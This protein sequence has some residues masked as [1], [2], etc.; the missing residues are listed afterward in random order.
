MAAT[1]LCEGD[2]Y[3]LAN[4]YYLCCFVLGRSTTICR[5]DNVAAGSEDNG[6]WFE[7]FAAVRGPSAVLDR[8]QGVRP[9]ALSLTL[10]RGNVAHSSKT[11]GITYYSPGWRPTD[12]EQVIEDTKSYR[13]LISGMLVHANVNIAIVGGVLADNMKGIWYFQN[14]NIRLENLDVIGYSSEYKAVLGAT[15]SEY[16][17]VSAPSSGQLAGIQIHPWRLGVKGPS[18]LVPQGLEAIDIR[19]SGFGNGCDGAAFEMNTQHVW[20]KTYDS[21]D[22]FRGISFGDAS[23]MADVC[24]AMALGVN[25]IAMHDQDGSFGSGSEGFVVSEEVSVTTFAGSCSSIGG[26]L[27]FCEGACLRQIDIRTN[28]AY[29]TENIEMV[30][31]DGSTE[32]TASWSHY[33]HQEFF[34]EVNVGQNTLTTHD[35]WYGLA[36]PEGNFQISFR[37]IETGEAAWPDYAEIV[38]A[39]APE[40]SGYATNVE[41]TMPE[42]DS[43]RCSSFIKD[44]DIEGGFDSAGLFG[45]WQQQGLALSFVSPGFGGTGSA[46]TGT[47]NSGSSSQ[48]I[49]Q[50]LD[51]SCFEPWTVYE[52]DAKVH[53]G[54]GSCP[55]AMLD[56]YYDDGS[57]AVFE[58]GSVSGAA[59][60][61]W[62]NMSGSFT[63][64]ASYDDPTR[65]KFV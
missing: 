48:Y 16:F 49:A 28:N 15:G 63:M 5:I 30:I 62:Y 11:H 31:G 6:Y 27:S 33:T 55:R 34:P 2:I 18:G 50:W 60:E 42:F 4:V 59:V 44:G 1:I 17:C 65:G 12:G 38:Y 36:L 20:K 64:D 32:A 24:A 45:P 3:T 57:I 56:F 53:C 51:V 19:F 58:L 35:G 41:L 23:I 47:G 43:L 54:G 22:K 21:I 61:G 25:T 29:S 52:F 26:C 7:T 14:E 8:A 39:Q 37:D 46:L 9:V 13:N 10:F 40:C